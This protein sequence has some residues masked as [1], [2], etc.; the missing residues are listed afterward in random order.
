[1][2]RRESAEFHLRLADHV[3][4]GYAATYLS[5]TG[6]ET[7]VFAIR[8]DDETRASR[9][10]TLSASERSRAGR[11][12]LVIGATVAVISAPA[13]DDCVD[14]VQQHLESLR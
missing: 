7:S 8:F 2:D 4:E 12:R 5:T 10:T 13:L 6:A 3:V 1:M 9:A 14:A 11:L